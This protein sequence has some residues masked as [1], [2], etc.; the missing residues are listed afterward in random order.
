MAGEET[1]QAPSGGEVEVKV[2]PKSN[3]LQ[4]LEPFPKWDGKDI[5][6]RLPEVQSTL[7]PV[8]GAVLAYTHRLLGQGTARVLMLQHTK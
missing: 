3:R 1:Y 2:D 8:P 6:V 5:E 7:G 4:I